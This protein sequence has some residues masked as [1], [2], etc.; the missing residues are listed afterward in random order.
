MRNHEQSDEIVNSISSQDIVIYMAEFTKIGNF[1]GQA[2]YRERLWTLYHKAL[3]DEDVAAEFYAL[4]QE[5]RAQR[6]KFLE[7]QVTER[8]N[9]KEGSTMLYGSKRA[10]VKT[11][12]DR[13]VIVLEGTTKAKVVSA[14]ALRPLPPGKD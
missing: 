12:R 3:T 4:A 13:V 7:K 8:E 10:L 14:S 5:V 1:E 9:I 11:V 2:A 6:Q